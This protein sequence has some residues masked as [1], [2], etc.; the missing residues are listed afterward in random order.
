LKEDVN[1]YF[2]RKW[3]LSF[4][5]N[6][7][8]HKIVLNDRCVRCSE[9][10]NYFQASRKDNI[11]HIYICKFCGF[12][13]RTATFKTQL[14]IPS[15]FEIEYQKHLEDVLKEGWV[16]NRIGSTYSHLYFKGIYLIMRS[17]CGKQARRFCELVA[18]FYNVDRLPS[19]LFNSVKLLEMRS[20]ADRRSLNILV[21]HII[22]N[23]HQDFVKL[24]EGNKIWF[25]KLAPFKN[26]DFPFW[27]WKVINEH[28]SRPTYTR[29]ELEVNSFCKYMKSQSKLFSTK[30]LRERFG[31]TSY[32]HLVEKKLIFHKPIESR[33][34]LYCHD[35]ENQVRSSSRTKRPANNYRYHCK[36]CKIS[37]TPNPLPKGYSQETLNTAIKLKKEEL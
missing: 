36:I 15:S 29:S 14:Y 32:R 37:Y 4:V 28:L 8:K 1:P 6:C 17:L 18:E 24:C 30:E 16:E 7:I 26:N 27:Y 20:I 23:W 22:T 2:R 33:E 21:G 34:C 12:D 11:I 25:K 10:L 35:T 19:T 5:V 9:P 13:L 31:N 3:R